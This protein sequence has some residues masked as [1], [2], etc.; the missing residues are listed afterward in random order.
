M[1]PTDE[2]QKRFE[3]FLEE[4]KT[5]E[6]RREAMKDALVKLQVAVDD[7]EWEDVCEI[8]LEFVASAAYMNFIQDL[9]Q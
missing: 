9:Q 8:A 4:I 7:D 5:P 1:K 6:E 2:Q 3:Q